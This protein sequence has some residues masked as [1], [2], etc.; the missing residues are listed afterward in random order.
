MEWFGVV[1]IG[2]FVALIVIATPLVW[3][4]ARRRWLS[5]SG[6]LF[7]CAVRSVDAAASPDWVLAAARYSGEDLEIFRIFSLSFRPKWQFRRRL[8]EIV[9]QRE[10]DATEAVVLFEGQHIARLQ[11]EGQEWDIALDPQS[12]TGLMSWL[13][14]A[15]PG[16]A[17][18]QA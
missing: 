4:F 2:V 6:G 1:L 12:L 10:P 9:G 7:D 3:L 18:Q 14:A 13:E 11:I 17:H 15:P 5:R 16:P 8:I